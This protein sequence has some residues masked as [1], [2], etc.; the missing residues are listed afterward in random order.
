MIASAAARS[1]V[2]NP[3]TR[4]RPALASHHRGRPRTTTNGRRRRGLLLLHLRFKSTVRL[5]TTD[6][7]SAARRAAAATTTTTA[8]AEESVPIGA[9]LLAAAAGVGV[10]AAAARIVEAAT[11]DSCPPYEHRR[12]AHRYDQT[13]FGGRFARMLLACD[14]SLLL[15][16]GEEVRSSRQRL[17]DAADDDDEQ[18]QKRRRLSPAESRSLWEHRRIVESALHPDTGEVIPRPFRMSGYVPFNG[19]ICV[20]MVAATST[21]PLLFWSWANQ[22]Q[23]A[24]VNYYNR[25]ASA[26]MTNE[27]LLRS[28]AAAVGSALAVV[29]GLSTF[30]RKR[31]PPHRARALMK[32]VAFP[33]AVVASS[34][35][36]YVVRSPEIDAGIPVLDERGDPV[37]GDDGAA[38]APSSIAARKGVEQ[39]TA[40]RAILQAPVY[41]LP[42]LLMGSLPV[43]KNAV[44]RNPATRV[45]LT[46]F[47]VLVSFGLGLPATIAIF[48]QVSSM[49][50]S[51]LEPRFRD[52]V[53]PETRKPY[54]VLYYNKGCDEN[55]YEYE[56]EYDDEQE[57][58]ERAGTFPGS[59]AIARNGRISAIP[60]SIIDHRSSSIDRNTA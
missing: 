25:N 31:W 19:P 53:D 38:A 49:K 8:A 40:S 35:N 9:S 54:G 10:V 16:T 45:P 27:T 21:A 24:L 57:E 12:G 3:G 55:E 52:L 22:S 1:V 20:S 7:K 14:P 23:N 5:P 48:P 51:D 36:C 17:L 47:L 4:C 28:Y 42:S 2:V 33:S 29:L 37:V 15:R 43:L 34:L 13:T 59:R 41:F 56:Y 39:T 32:Y 26:P 60:E 18:Q 46:T 44:A 58:E 50:Q 11:A 6:G 30:V